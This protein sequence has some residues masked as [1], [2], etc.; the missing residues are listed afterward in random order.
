MRR[1]PDD[2]LAGPGSLAAFAAWL[3]GTAY[4]PR[5]PC[6]RVEE[7]A[8]GHPLAAGAAA[9]STTPCRPTIWD[10]IDADEAAVTS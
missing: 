4:S 5:T 8:P 10:E 1:C 7:V 6:D 2:L 9:C 3:T